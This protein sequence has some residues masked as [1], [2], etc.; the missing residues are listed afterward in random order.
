MNW[1]FFLLCQYT[2]FN[3]NLLGHQTMFSRKPIHKIPF[4]NIKKK[5]RNFMENLLSIYE[6]CHL[7]Y[8]KSSHT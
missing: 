7:V 6:V 8:F 2:K 3:T 1:N 4:L 5:T